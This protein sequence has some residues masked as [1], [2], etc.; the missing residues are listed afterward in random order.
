MGLRFKKKKIY[1]AYNRTEYNIIKGGEKMDINW[2]AVIIGSYI[3]NCIKYYL[4]INNRKLRW[5]PCDTF[6]NYICWLHCWRRLQN[7]AIHG[8]LVGVIGGLILVY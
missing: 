5:I 1:G 6:S 8:A 3:S 4:W 7:G 2:K